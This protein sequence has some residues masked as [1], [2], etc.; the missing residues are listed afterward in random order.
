M[1]SF[2]QHESVLFYRVISMICQTLVYGLPLPIFVLCKELLTFPCMLYRGL[3]VS[4]PH[5]NICHDVRTP[6]RA[7]RQWFSKIFCA[8]NRSKG[9]V[10]QSRRTLFVTTL[11]MFT[12][13][14][15]YWISSVVVTV[16][17]I[18]AW[19]SGLDPNTHNP[20][21]WL[22]MFSSILLI[23]VSHTESHTP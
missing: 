17:V 23:N 3:L 5:L 19:F 10:T 16:S 22:P 20:P 8:R 4:H 2:N 11:L 13:S 18:T 15:I 14:T 7:L 6:R 9:L 12:F 21:N 1:A